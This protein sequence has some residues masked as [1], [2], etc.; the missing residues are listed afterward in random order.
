ME[1][2]VMPQPLIS[3]R[4]QHAAG[5]REFDGNGPDF[6]LY[7]ALEISNDNL[8]YLF[9]Y[10]KFIETKPDSTTFEGN[11]SMPLFNTERDS[12]GFKI[13][14]IV[15]PSTFEYASTDRDHAVNKYLIGVGSHSLVREIEVMGDSDG[16]IFGD[17]D[18]PWMSVYFN[19]IRIELFEPSSIKNAP[20]WVNPKS[21]RPKMPLFFQQ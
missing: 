21:F 12:P 1:I 20:T 9:W 8:L 15:T 16:G 18:S 7:I 3:I 14:R 17:D 11:G 6:R 19:P 5:D 13:K 2:L 10:M 4:P